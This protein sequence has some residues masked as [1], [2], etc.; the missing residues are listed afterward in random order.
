MSRSRQDRPYRT[1]RRAGGGGGGGDSTYIHSQKERKERHQGVSERT[2][3]QGEV[4]KPD[5]RRAY[6]KQG[7]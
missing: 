5:T 4:A 1:I 7:K 2:K 6:S 3:G